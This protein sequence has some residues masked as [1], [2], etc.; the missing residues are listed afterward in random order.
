MRAA[1]PAVIIFT[2]VGV[3][4]ALYAFVCHVR[5]ERVA[6]VAMKQLRAAQPAVWQSLGWLLR[7]ANP[8][9]TINVLRTRHHITD[10]QFDRQCELVKR[11]QRHQWFAVAV[12]LVCI[13]MVLIG[14]R[15]WD[16]RFD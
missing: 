8:A 2:V 10:P 12:A 4:A 14:A 1:T 5:A 3:I 13:V 9:F 7:L 6:Q 15:F 11:H 16:W